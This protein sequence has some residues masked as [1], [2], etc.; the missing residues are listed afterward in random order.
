MTT[1][2][3]ARIGLVCALALPWQPPR[4]EAAPLEAPATSVATAAFD[5]AAAVRTSGKLV[6][7]VVVPLCDNAQVDCGST[8][9]GDPRNLE[10]N[11][12]WGAVFGQARFFSRKAGGWEK[13]SRARAASPM[14]ERAVFRKRVP[15][16]PYGRTEPIELI[17]VLDA[18]EGDAID[19]AVDAFFGA[20]EGDSSVT[21]EDAGVPRTEPIH[22]VGFAGHNRMMDGK[23][24]P[25]PKVASTARARPS[26]VLACDSK[27]YFDAPLVARGSAPLLLTKAL[28]APE[29]YVVEATVL[30][31]AA[32]A[33]RVEIRARAGAAYAKW[34]GLKESSGLSI[35][36]KPE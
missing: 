19:M 16:A 23:R 9:A 1:H 15:G 3:L 8:R 27:S 2:T 20:T 4:A 7:Q 33:S 31:I 14:L 5:L 10:H 12:Y 25:E 21:F 24:A 18:Y 17:V 36:A 32:K 11:L 30:G 26:F 13:V 29:G 28:M 34:Q 35:F 22:V 6:V